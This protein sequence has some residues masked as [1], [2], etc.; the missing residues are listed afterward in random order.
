M[1]AIAR[2]LI[3][4][5]LLILMDEPSEGLSQKVIARVEE[6]C[7]RLVGEGMSVLLVEQNLEMAQKLADRAYVFLNGQVALEE[8]GEDFRLDRDRVAAYLNLNV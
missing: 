6:V 2:A 1:L 8:S 4:D 3:S 7:L 5:P